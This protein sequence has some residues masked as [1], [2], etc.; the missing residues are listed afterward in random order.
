M[1]GPDPH[2]GECQAQ[3]APE[4]FFC[5]CCGTRARDPVSPPVLG[6]GPELLVFDCR[7]CGAS[8]HFSPQEEALT[9]PFCD[10]VD[11]SRVGGPAAQEPPREIPFTLL[12]EAATQASSG[13]ISSL[14]FRPS[15]LGAAAHLGD[16]RP[17][18]LPCWVFGA[19]ARCTWTADSSRTPSGTRGDWIPL[20]GE[21]QGHYEPLY[22]VA[23]G[24][25]TEEEVASLLPFNEDQDPLT[26]GTHEAPED[27]V[28]ESFAMARK[29][30]RPRARELLREA[31]RRDCRSL[32]PGRC[33]NL[34]LELRILRMRSR[35]LR[36]P[37][38]VVAYQY[39]GRT[40]RIL[41]N[42]QSGRVTGSAPWSWRK[43]L[44]LATSLLGLLLLGLWFATQASR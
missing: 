44:A 16:L 4:D 8:M 34:H 29:Y 35:P 39:Q 19:T 22:V 17:V 33:R 36:V 41:V 2:C 6:G 20:S 30:A 37:V 24:A 42:G 40:Y 31:A 7:G 25:L 38:W 12:R 15:D 3:L 10:S 26:S 11:L 32:V 1:S 9:C 13:W 43:L 5:A 21:H 18:H 28:S 27:L 14:W 23:S